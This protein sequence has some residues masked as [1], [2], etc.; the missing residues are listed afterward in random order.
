MNELPPLNTNSTALPLFAFGRSVI[1]DDIAPLPEMAVPQTQNHRMIRK[2]LT[3]SSL[4]NSHNNPLRQPSRMPIIHDSED[5]KPGNTFFGLLKLK[6]K[7][8]VNANKT[9]K[10]AELGGRRTGLSAPTE[11]P[12]EMCIEE[13]LR[14]KWE[15]GN[16]VRYNRH[17]NLWKKVDKEG[18]QTKSVV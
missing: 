8:R 10:V 5:Q 1:R 11:A 18:W 12:T 9:A 16:E 7:S 17:R 14:I 4:G 13:D 15:L 6:A 2:S 3:T